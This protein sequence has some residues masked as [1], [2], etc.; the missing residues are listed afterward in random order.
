MFISAKINNNDNALYICTLYHYL[1]ISLIKFDQSLY[2][3]S[4]T[5]PK[6][7]SVH[8]RSS[9]FDTPS[10]INVPLTQCSHGIT[11]TLMLQSIVV[12]LF[13]TTRFT[14]LVFLS[15]LGFLFCHY[16]CCCCC[17]SLV[18]TWFLVA[19]LFFLILIFLILIFL[20]L[21]RS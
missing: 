16:Y 5:V 15:D 11:V 8:I 21:C 6:C 18:E 1:S 4:T 13:I 14:V 7:Y 19:L 9:R 10:P 12:V 17:C 20:L 3:I 2:G